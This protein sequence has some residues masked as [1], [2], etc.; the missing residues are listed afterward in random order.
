MSP[1]SHLKLWI[2]RNKPKDLRKRTNQRVQAPRPVA[3]TPY[4]A[5]THDGTPHQL[6]P[7]LQT[8]EYAHEGYHPPRFES[9]ADGGRST[10]EEEGGETDGETD[11]E[12]GEGGVRRPTFS[13]AK[14]G[15]EALNAFFF[16]GS[17]APPQTTSQF[18]L[19]VDILRHDSPDLPDPR[20]AINLA[21]R[22]EYSA[23]STPPQLAYER[24]SSFAQP[25]PKATT[26]HT[27][28]LLALLTNQNPVASP[29]PPKVTRRQP[30]NS[31]AEHIEGPTEGGGLLDIFKTGSRSNLAAY[32]SANLLTS[33]SPFGERSTTTVTSNSSLE[34]GVAPSIL[35][36][37]SAPPIE[38]EGFGTT[39][40]LTEAERGET[41][42]EEKRTALMRAL[43]SVQS[44][45]PP[46]AESGLVGTPVR[47]EE[48]SSAEGMRALFGSG[49]SSGRE[50]EEEE[51]R[52][53][54]DELGWP[55]VAPSRQEDV[56][57][58]GMRRLRID[59]EETSFGSPPSQGAWPGSQ[60]ALPFPGEV[61]PL[62][63]AT[64][65]QSDGQQVRMMKSANQLGGG[66]G[67]SNLL[68]ILNGAGA[69]PSNGS[70]NKSSHSQSSP[71]TYSPQSA[72]Q[73]LPPPH[74][75]SNGQPT[76]YLPSPPH[77]S[78][79]LPFPP[80]YAPNYPQQQQHP[81]QIPYP[82]QHL[83][84]G[85]LPYPSQPPFGY[86]SHPQAQPLPFSP[87][88]N[89][90][91]G[92]PTALP[93]SGPSFLPPPQGFAPAFP[94]GYYPPPPQFAPPSLPQ[95]MML[96]PQQQQQQQQ[97]Q[98]PRVGQGNNSGHL[99][100]LLNGRG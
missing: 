100:G 43:F 50:Q 87:F 93:T 90:P 77:P 27:N 1:H 70:S 68:S 49:R 94:P 57:L 44:K 5:H 48:G 8:D 25:R 11:F 28:T 86:P 51:P 39:H 62:V 29:P 6:P 61:S 73:N 75:H 3:P 40:V 34:G 84:P 65:L 98:Q 46:P 79:P 30:S 41:E 13:D 36:A 99:L 89:A 33:P 69:G 95:G 22:D 55:N 47:R 24:Q 26:Q 14:S 15:T 54:R 35:F 18:S 19:P 83:P 38:A 66:G 12:H 4:H 32:S 9:D 16:G 92:Y 31:S 91:P 20:T 64:R 85:S 88:G 56:E 74:A 78:Q 23:G 96:P 81:Q 97:V 58:D 37:D 71:S 10:S 52:Q 82:P 80:Q 59:G 60:P 72:Q 45:T 2:D 53:G 76:S 63:A 17:S 7:H 21:N 42:M 67:G